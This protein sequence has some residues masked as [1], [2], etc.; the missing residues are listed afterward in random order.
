MSQFNSIF[1]PLSNKLA[2]LA[3]ITLLAVAA[4]FAST[5][6]MSAQTCVQNLVVNLNGKCEA[7]VSVAMVVVGSSSGLRVQIN[8]NNPG[9]DVSPNAKVNTVSPAS[10]WTYGVFNAS[11]QLVC[12]GT[13][14][15][16]DKFRPVFTDSTR[17]HWNLIDTIVT[18]ADNLD[19]IY[20]ASGTN[21]GTFASTPSG[22]WYTGRPFLVDSCE[23]ITYGVAASETTVASGAL[24]KWMGIKLTNQGSSDSRLDSIGLWPTQAVGT[25]QMKVTDYLESP[26]CDSC[27]FQYK[28]RRSFQ[29]IDRRGNDTTLNQIIYFQRP[30]NRGTQADPH[31]SRTE[32]TT[33][34]NIPGLSPGFSDT[35]ARGPGNLGEFGP[36]GASPKR[37]YITYNGP[38]SYTDRMTVVGSSGAYTKTRYN[39]P[40]GNG[41]DTFQ[42][43]MQGSTCVT[44][45]STTEEHR[46]LL[47]AIYVAR[48]TTPIGAQD[49]VSLFDDVVRTRFNYSV[50]FQ[51]TFF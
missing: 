32:F 6:Q 19:N 3:G 24:I 23:A 10:G 47:R 37:A 16:M 26:Q 41:V 40:G 21:S 49:S 7:D 27:G 28:L 42:F 22:T 46:A 17:R 44:P 13:I 39:G 18:W 20:N 25:I 5:Q 12:Q 2:R 11:N 30:A 48:D 36:F 38:P 15:V 4:L 29:F 35:I 14:V 34:C 51:T 33:D 1:S 8:D 31:T 9:D 50:E 45:P 43:N